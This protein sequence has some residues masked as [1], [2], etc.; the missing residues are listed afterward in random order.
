MFRFDAKIGCYFYPNH[1]T[2][3]NEVLYLN[4][5]LTYEKNEQK[6]E[7]IK[8]IKLGLKIPQNVEDYQDFTEKMKQ[9]EKQFLSQI[10]FFY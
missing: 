3:D 8:V 5:G 7:N 1:S 9:S 2:A 4:Q 6:R 10:Q